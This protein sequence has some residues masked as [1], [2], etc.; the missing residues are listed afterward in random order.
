[1][2]LEIIFI[3]FISIE[4]FRIYYS[5]MKIFLLTL[6][7][8]VFSCSEINKKRLIGAKLLYVFDFFPNDWIVLFVKR[9]LILQKI[10]KSCFPAL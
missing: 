6:I 5:W 7:I 10:L 2:N 8:K 1:M 3:G 9:K 4:I